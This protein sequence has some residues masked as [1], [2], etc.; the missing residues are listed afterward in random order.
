MGKFDAVIEKYSTNKVTTDNI[1]FAISSIKDGTRREHI[2]EN[3]TADYRGMAHDEANAMLEDLFA[4]NGG[5]FKI[6]NR[7]GYLFGIVLLFIGGA[8]AFYIFYVFYYGGVLVRPI[9]VFLGA[10]SGLLGGLGYI[11]QSIRGKYRHEHDPFS[12][13]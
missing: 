9:L 10:I 8:C 4:T 7:N 3:L 6:E 12:E 5:E 11:I 1:D 2:L 13:N